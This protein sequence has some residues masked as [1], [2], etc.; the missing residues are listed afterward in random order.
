MTQV[1]PKKSRRAFVEGALSLLAAAL[2]AL[3]AYLGLQA[4]W[5]TEARDNARSTVEQRD[6][7]LD[8]LSSRVAALEAKNQQLGDENGQLRNQLGLPAPVGDVLPPESATVRR[9]GQVTVAVQGSRIN[10]DAPVTDTQWTGDYYELSYN[11]R[12]IGFYYGD[13]LPTGSTQATYEYC[14][15]QT[16]YLDGGR[17][18][19]EIGTVK[20]GDYVCV[21][22]NQKRI[23][24]VKILSF[25][26]D[27]A[28]FD[29]VVYDPPLT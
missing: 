9:S 7:Q 2:T 25:D 3:S 12:E 1:Q 18:T 28:V 6:A 29:V 20:P 16:G 8:D 22:T 24:A 4:T 27:K 19:V 15:T 17:A 10:L 14:S 5:A 13:Y 11:A 21:K 26:A 23:A